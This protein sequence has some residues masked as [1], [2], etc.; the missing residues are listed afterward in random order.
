MSQDNSHKASNA[1]WTPHEFLAVVSHELR[2]V[3]WPILGWAEVISRRPDDANTLA[4]GIRVIKRSARLQAVLINQL[5]DFRGSVAGASGRI[6]RVLCW[7]QPYKS[8]RN[9]DAT[10]QGQAGRTT[11]SV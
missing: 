4:N 5:L 1:G 10:G 6:F 3:T 11:C 7:Y 2:N 9:D 8:H